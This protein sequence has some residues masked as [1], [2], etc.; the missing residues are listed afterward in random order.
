MF[1]S[2]GH[3]RCPRQ[4]C[5][6]SDDAE[7]AKPNDPYPCHPRWTPLGVAIY[8]GSENIVHSLLER[9]DTNSTC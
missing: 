6:A 5:V 4:S 1:R 9:D 7:Q 8:N 3:L 2:R